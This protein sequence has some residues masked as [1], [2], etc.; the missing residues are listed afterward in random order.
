[1]L[2]LANGFAALTGLVFTLA[3]GYGSD[4]YGRR[5]IILL[6]F[7]AYAIF[8]IVYIFVVNPWI[9]T[10]LWI[11]PLY[12]LV[13][14]ASYAA[15]ADLSKVTRRGRAMSTIATANS[16][17]SGIGPIIGGV[18]IQFLIPTLRGN[19]LFAVVFNTLAFV[20][21]L[22]LVPETLRRRKQ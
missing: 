4:R 20:L 22:F 1:M 7:A 8:M 17:G 13:Y 18:L 2:G 16:L 6:G 21:V 3:A 12:P 14:T 19:M 15:A 9:A 10:I 11:I 5:P